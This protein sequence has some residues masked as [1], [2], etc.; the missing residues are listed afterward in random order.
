V[1]HD[2]QFDDARLAVNLAQTMTRLRRHPGQLH[3]GRRDFT[4][5]GEMI[6][7]CLATDMET[8]K[9]EIHARVVVNATGVFTDEILKM[10]NPE[11]KPIIT[12]SQGVHLVLDKE[13][14]ARRF[15]H[16]GPPDSRRPGALRGALA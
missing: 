14:S 16:H 1:Y 12:A 9:Y 6:D 3:E 4:R 15:G 11:A 2:G 8:G 5:A 10:E 7:G 13:F